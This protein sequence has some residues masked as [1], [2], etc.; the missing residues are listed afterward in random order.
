MLFLFTRFLSLFFSRCVGQCQHPSFCL[1][2]DSSAIPSPA[3][4][5]LLFLSRIG[6]VTDYET[7]VHSDHH[8][9][10][11]L[12]CLPPSPLTFPLI[13]HLPPRLL[14]LTRQGHQY[15]LIS[16]R[17]M[18]PVMHLIHPFHTCLDNETPAYIPLI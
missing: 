4:S 7:L 17:F 8:P 1:V 5:F 16:P 11:P 9:P 6:K 14:S 13:A 12:A 3:L 18:L 10:R 15:L 2:I